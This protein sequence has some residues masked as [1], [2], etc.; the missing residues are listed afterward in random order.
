MFYTI[1]TLKENLI[2]K[3][4]INFLMLVALSYIVS[5]CATSRG[6]S[7]YNTQQIKPPIKKIVNLNTTD[8][9]KEYPLEYKVSVDKPQV[10]AESCNIIKRFEQF[11]PKPYRCPGGAL[12]VG[13]GFDIKRVKRR[14]MS[15][16]EASKH[17]TRLV[18]DTE[19]FVRSKVHNKITK[20]QM[21][22]LISFVYN[23]GEPSFEQS[24]MLKYINHNK[25][26]KA[27][28]EFNRWVYVGSSKHHKTLKNLV[29][30]RRI[31]KSIF[32]NNSGSYT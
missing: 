5:G 22:A 1:N 23:V 11:S 24:T 27:S 20:N 7:S 8:V 30:R 15:E 12:T 25:I 17:L 4:F 6:L 21:V 19:A 28:K 14:R 32:N 16:K 18:S 29:A 9:P 2:N 3:T 13:Y 10:I 26:N 31:E